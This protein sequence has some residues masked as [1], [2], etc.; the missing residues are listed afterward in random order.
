MAEDYLRQLYRNGL[1]YYAGLA[2]HQ[3][4]FEEVKARYGRCARKIRSRLTQK[5]VVWL[6]SL[7]DA[8]YEMECIH[9]ETA[10]AEGFRLCARLTGELNARA[11]SG[12]GCGFRLKLRYSFGH[13]PRCAVGQGGR[14]D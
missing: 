4:G 10:F 9:C 1:D 5:Q 7:I 14:P 13:G 6:K 8:Q 2:A 3:P 11:V 12:A